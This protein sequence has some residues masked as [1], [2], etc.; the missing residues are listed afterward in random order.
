MPYADPEKRK[1]YHKEYMNRY[2]K[3]Y[4]SRPDRKARKANR[5]HSRDR[6]AMAEYYRQRRATPEGREYTRQ[7][8]KLNRTDPERRVKY[9]ARRKVRE[10]IKRGKIQRQPCQECGGEAQA[11]HDDYSRPLDV[12]WYCQPCHLRIFHRTGG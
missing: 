5:N 10:A 12:R 1:A 6:E 2:S 3:E 11:H 7:Q 4:E 8:D 9:L